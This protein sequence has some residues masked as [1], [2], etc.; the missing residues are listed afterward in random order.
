[1]KDCRDKLT[2]ISLI[3]LITLILLRRHSFEQKNIDFDRVS[4]YDAAT[5]AL[6]RVQEDPVYTFEDGTHVYLYDA[7]YD[8]ASYYVMDNE[9]LLLMVAETQRPDHFEFS[10]SADGQD[11]TIQYDELDDKIKA[12]VDE[13]LKDDSTYY[14]LESELEFAYNSYQEKAKSYTPFE[15]M[16]SFYLTS[17]SEKQLG[18]TFETDRVY[19]KSGSGLT[20]DS[21]VTVSTREFLIDH[22]EGLLIQ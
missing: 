1:M 13:I 4:S 15:I 9:Q 19:I 22:A 6:S 21:T 3:I 12:A 11:V 8:N 20:G 16:N 2:V 17:Y 10:V 5:L 18:F 14:D 7:S